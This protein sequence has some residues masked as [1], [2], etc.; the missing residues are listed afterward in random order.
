MGTELENLAPPWSRKE[1]PCLPEMEGE[2]IWAHQA[3][4]I[5]SSVCVRERF[6]THTEPPNL[7]TGLD[8][9]G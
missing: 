5:L 7:S 1:V 9:G 2:E 8:L 3:L 4:N 6:T